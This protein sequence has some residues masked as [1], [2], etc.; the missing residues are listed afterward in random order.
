LAQI[1]QEGCCAIHLLS[2]EIPISITRKYE[3]ILD[4][5]IKLQAFLQVAYQIPIC[6]DSLSADNNMLEK[7]GLF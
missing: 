6:C 7:P 4:S 1:D 2:F 5:S 3:S